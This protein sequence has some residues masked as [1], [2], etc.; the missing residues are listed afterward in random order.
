MLDW[1]YNLLP[2]SERAV[3]RGVSAFV[4]AFSLERAQ[5]V[6][7][8]DA[9]EREQIAEAIAGLVTKSLIAVE[10]SH[11]GT[12]YRLLDTTRAYVLAKMPDD[13]ERNTIARRQ[14]IDCRES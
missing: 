10:S 11:T 6:A 1:S 7:A 4:G 2:E 5:C 8:G 14:A 13:G 3:L 9:L 12:L